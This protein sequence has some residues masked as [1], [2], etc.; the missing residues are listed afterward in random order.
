MAKVS[1]MVKTACDLLDSLFMLVEAIV[2]DLFPSMIRSSISWA[3]TTSSWDRP[4]IT[5]LIEYRAVATEDVDDDDILS[6]LI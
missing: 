1:L 2:L 3:E 5:K 4:S 6:H